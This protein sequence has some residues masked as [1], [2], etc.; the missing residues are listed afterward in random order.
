VPV[1]GGPVALAADEM[2]AWVATRDGELLHVDPAADRVLDRLRF[3]KSPYTIGVG[4]G[5]VWIAVGS[6]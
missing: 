5:R 4:F 1:S 2:G 6:V 3:D